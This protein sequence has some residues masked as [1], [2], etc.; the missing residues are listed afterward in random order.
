[1]KMEQRD[2]HRHLLLKNGRTAQACWI[3]A[4][5]VMLVPFLFISCR[6]APVWTVIPEDGYTSDTFTDTKEDA[7]STNP[8]AVT[9]SVQTKPETEHKK[10]PTS[11]DLQ[12]ASSVSESGN[13]NHSGV[14]P[15]T[16]DPV[17]ITPTETEVPKLPVFETNRSETD[18]SPSETEAPVKSPDVTEYPETASPETAS[19]ETTPPESH[20]NPPSSDIVLFE[21]V[22]RYVYT[23]LSDLDKQQYQIILDA[24]LKQT[25]SCSFS[26][27]YSKTKIRKLIDAVL[28]DY[29]EI[30]WT[31]GAGIYYSFPDGTKAFSFQYIMTDEEIKQTQTAINAARDDFLQNVSDLNT[32]YEKA[33]AVYEYLIMNTGYDTETYQ[34]GLLQEEID[35]VTQT[36]CD[37]LLKHCAVCTGYAKAAQYLLHSLGIEA[38]FAAGTASGSNH[39][40]LCYRMNGCYY[41]MDPCWGDPTDSEYKDTGRINYLYFALSEEELS[42][43]HSLDVSYQL[44]VCQGGDDTYFHHN[45]LLFETYDSE[46]LCYALQ[47]TVLARGTVLTFRYTSYTAYETALSDL[48]T[49]GTLHT[50]VGDAAG[51]AGIASSSL[52]ISYSKKDAYNL[53]T[54]YI[55][56]TDT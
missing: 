52:Q 29:P 49:N 50:L 14:K 30:F 22:P 15:E 21:T 12:T 18:R 11:D 33:L 48:F 56:Y 26:E 55:A 32:D 35:S 42:L 1:M 34:K 44:P 54:L 39:A 13:E 38:T 9:D 16:R 25:A 5:F 17:E 41:Y 20:Q 40:W 47:K 36:M 3:A 23:T 45:G 2:L 19:P 24:I 6:K 27:K 7:E 53:I 10:E 31:T 4:F 37:A 46:D 28:A 8:P 43:T 51:Q